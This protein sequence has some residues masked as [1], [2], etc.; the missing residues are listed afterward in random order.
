MQ[1]MLSLLRAQ[2]D[3]LAQSVIRSAH[4]TSKTVSTAE[5]LT[6]GLIAA[7]LGDIPGASMVL[8]G[9]A[10]TYCDE[11]KHQV[12]GVKQETLDLHTAVSQETACELALGSLELFSSDIAVSATGYAGP[13]GGTEQDPVG[14]FYLGICVRGRDGNPLKPR[15]IRC[16]HEGDRSTVRSYAVHDALGLVIETLT[17]ME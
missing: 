2:N 14:T 11:I 5:S 6:A 13:G 7:T 12:L 16:Y 3:E 1:D 8:R 15:S 10:V 9:G 17:A 4:A